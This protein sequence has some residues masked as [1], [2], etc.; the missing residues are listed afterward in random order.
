MNTLKTLKVMFVGFPYEKKIPDTIGHDS[1]WKYLKENSCEHYDVCVI[2]C[3]CFV[4]RN[5]NS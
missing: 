3:E 2:L 4:K 1:I 5:F